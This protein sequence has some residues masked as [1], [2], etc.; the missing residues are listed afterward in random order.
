MP[1]TKYMFGGMR[2]WRVQDKFLAGS[3]HS[4]AWRQEELLQV[5]NS[6]S[7]T[8]MQG[9][10]LRLPDSCF[11]DPYDLEALHAIDDKLAQIVPESEWEAHANCSLGEC[12][13]HF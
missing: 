13:P 8:S 2:K 5:A 7:S 10:H 1:F 3:F 4:S 11:K 12:F 6:D 9:M